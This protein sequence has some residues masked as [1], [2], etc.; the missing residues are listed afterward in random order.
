MSAKLIIVFFL[1]L[2]TGIFSYFLQRRINESKMVARRLEDLVTRARNMEGK[3][4]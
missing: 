2:A 3:S 4:C 1:M